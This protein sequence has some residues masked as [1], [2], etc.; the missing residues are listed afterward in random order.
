[1]ISNLSSFRMI[2]K[3]GKSRRRLSFRL[4]VGKIFI[5]AL[6]VASFGV[7]GRIAY[8]GYIQRNIL[9]KCAAGLSCPYQIDGLQIQSSLG[10]A[11]AQ[12]D[13]GAGLAVL[14]IILLAYVFLFMDRGSHSQRKTAEHLGTEDTDF[15]NI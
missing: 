12:L 1:M 3:L 15:S 13:M 5:L 10:T 8:G 4:T 9:E 11:R 2:E 7:G 14:G 6:A